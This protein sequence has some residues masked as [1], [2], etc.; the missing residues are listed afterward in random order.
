MGVTANN[1]AN[2]S[3]AGYK[4]DQSTFADLV[5]TT[6]NGAPG[7][8]NLVV[9]QGEKLN[10]TD[11][12]FTQGAV[13]E[14]GRAQ[15][16]ALLDRNTFFAVQSAN[17]AVRYTRDGSFQLSEQPNGNFYLATAAGDLVL[18]ANGQP[19]AV[20]DDQAQQN[21]GVYTF[22]NLD[23]LVKNGENTY[24][25]TN[26]SGAA[27]VVQGAKVQQKALEGSAVDMAGELSELITTNRAFSFNAKVVQ[28][29]DSI[30]QTVNS[31]R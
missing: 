27:T 8:N 14:T 30:M 24:L 29:A 11:T 12:V 28:M 15:D 10:K 25:A 6:V 23:G 5:Y 21:V 9:G 18:D 26:R 16:Y 7:P 22:S 13:Q 1:I 4:P 31:L 19:I 17:G 3:T 20:T 2:A